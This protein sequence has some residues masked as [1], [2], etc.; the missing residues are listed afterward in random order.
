MNSHSLNKYLFIPET[1]RGPKHGQDYDV[2]PT[3]PQYINIKIALNHKIRA[4]DLKVLMMFSH[5]LFGL[6]FCSF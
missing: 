4:K 1:S 2:T 3:P 5:G 6:L